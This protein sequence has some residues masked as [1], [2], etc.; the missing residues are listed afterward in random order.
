M[1]DD[2]T[3]TGWKGDLYQRWIEIG[4][5]QFLN[6]LGV[7]FE[8]NFVSVLT[9]ST[10]D[11]NP[12]RD[13]TWAILPNSAI[14]AGVLHCYPNQV[15]DEK[16]TWEEWFLLNGE[17]RHHLLSNHPFEGEEGVWTPETG[18]KDHPNEVLSTSWHY[19]NSKDLRP[20]LIK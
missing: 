15:G 12:Y 17:I 20:S 14:P 1:A 9:I 7:D 6:E 8:E 18:D 10:S 3:F 13:C 5:P 19:L 16:V 4:A 2:G 11:S